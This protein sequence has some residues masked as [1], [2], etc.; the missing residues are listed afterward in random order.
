MDFSGGFS[1]CETFRGKIRRIKCRPRLEFGPEIATIIRGHFGVD[2]RKFQKIQWRRHPEI[3]DESVPCRG[4]TCPE[5]LGP[6]SIPA[7]DISLPKGK[8]YHLRVY[9]F[10]MWHEQ[11]LKS[12]TNRLGPAKTYAL[13]GT[14]RTYAIKTRA[15]TDNSTTKKGPQKGNRGPV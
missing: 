6:D 2:R 12:R 14:P 1:S 7:T 10:F 15:P 13:R 11:V 3:A 5:R 8:R 4:R 9:P